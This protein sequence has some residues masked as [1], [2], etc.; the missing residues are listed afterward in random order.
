M[1]CQLLF[2]LSFVLLGLGCYVKPINT[3]ADLPILERE[4]DCP[5]ELYLS[6]GGVPELSSSFI[7]KNKLKQIY[8]VNGS[9]IDGNNDLKFDRE[10]FIQNINKIAPNPSASGTGVLNWEGKAIKVL[11]KNKSTDP[12]FKAVEQ[13]YIK[14]LKTAQ[15]LRPNIKWGYYSL[16]FRD[17]WNRNEKWEAKNDAVKK[18]L[19]A[20]D[21]IYPSVY[22]F[23]ENGNTSVS[24]KKDSLY[25]DANIKSALKYG[26]RYNKPVIPFYWHR[27]HNSNKKVG[28]QL[29]PWEEFK[30]HIIAGISAG[31][32]GKHV[33]GI[34]WW[35]SDKYFYNKNAI[36]KREVDKVNTFER[37]QNNLTLDYTSKIIDLFNEH[38]R[39]LNN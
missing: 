11:Y 38:C 39:E 29:I 19:E 3:A 10:K 34:V 14:V 30:E 1:K 18:I 13:E 16:P 5:L 36:V 6:L 17:Y 27:W 4:K 35:G 21:V 2:L 7:K 33:D 31:Y 20:S 15:K 28:M 22:D 12:T 25:V 37:Y 9:Y 32:Q 24:K 23:Y 8:F 26:K